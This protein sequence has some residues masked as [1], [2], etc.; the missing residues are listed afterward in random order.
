[1]ALYHTSE[2]LKADKNFILQAVRQNGI[3]LKHASETL[4]ADK[5][6]VL[7]AVKKH[8]M[9]VYYAT[10]TLRGDD[11]FITELATIV[12]KNPAVKSFFKSSWLTN[13]EFMSKLT[14]NL[15]QCHQVLALNH[16]NRHSQQ[17]SRDYSL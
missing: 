1:M 13:E 11:K 15:N 17:V 16:K 2:T 6:V 4:K 12:K 7:E 14:K 5:E 3:A 10:D 9:F 8:S